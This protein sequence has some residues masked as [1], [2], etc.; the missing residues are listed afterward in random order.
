MYSAIST[1]ECLEVLGPASKDGAVV[2]EKF[3][4][5]RTAQGTVDLM[6]GAIHCFQS[7]IQTSIVTEI[8]AQLG[9]HSQIVR[10]IIL[11]L[12]E[13]VLL[14]AACGPKGSLLHMTGCLCEVGLM[15][16]PVL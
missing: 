7:L 4:S 11:Y 5:F 12:S 10:P 13:F 2:S 15:S 6:G 16:C 1:E 9:F 8:S 14:D 3:L